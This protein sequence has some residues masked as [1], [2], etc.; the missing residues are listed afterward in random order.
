MLCPSESQRGVPGDMGWTNYHANAG[1]WAHLAGWDGV[2]GAVVVEE[3][4]PPLPPLRL[5]KILDGTSKTAALGEVVN[6]LTVEGTVP[7]ARPSRIADCFEFGGNP[8]PPGGGSLSLATIR[9]VFLRKDPLA[10]PVPWSGSWRYRGNPW[11]EGTMWMSWYNHLL[12]PDSTCWQAG[13]W[14]K[15]ISPATSYHG[16]M[17]N[18]V[19]VDGSVQSISSS[20]DMDVWT[21]MG[22]RAGPA[23]R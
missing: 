11:S 1:G 22:T 2:F 18:V 21:D 4:I 14:W 5:A 8:F 12:P 19:M 15:I 16:G 3:G 23:K 10:T 17:V 6:G 20:V 13:S 9:N 7:P